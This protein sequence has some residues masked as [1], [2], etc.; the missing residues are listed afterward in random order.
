M[1]F[2]L[3][4]ERR[5]VVLTNFWVTGYFGVK[6]RRVKLQGQEEELLSTVSSEL[7]RSK[8]YLS[9]FWDGASTF[10]FSYFIVFGEA[11]M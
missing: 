4:L 1:L 10:S 8:Q 5:L 7:H 3:Y 2:S 11:V 9:V 6:V